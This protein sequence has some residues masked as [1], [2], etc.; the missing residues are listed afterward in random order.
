M[1]TSVAPTRHPALILGF[2]NDEDESDDS[3]GGST[4]STA[5]RRARS[6]VVAG[7]EN[8]SVIHCV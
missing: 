8:E 3:K 7:D 1:S 6:D 4:G 2:V 5:I